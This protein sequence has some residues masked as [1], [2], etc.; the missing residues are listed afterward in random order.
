MERN[1]TTVKIDGKRSVT[2]KLPIDFVDRM[3]AEGVKEL[4][5][6]IDD[7]KGILVIRPKE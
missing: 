6:N 7:E 3:I 2:M 5:V 4:D 1:K